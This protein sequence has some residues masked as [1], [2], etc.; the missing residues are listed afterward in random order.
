MADQDIHPWMRPVLKDCSPDAQVIFLFMA[1]KRKLMSNDDMDYFDMQYWDYQDKKRKQAEKERKAER[2]DNIKY[3]MEVVTF[4]IMI[5]TILYSYLETILGRVW[6]WLLSLW[7]EWWLWHIKDWCSC[8]VCFVLYLRCR[9]ARLLYQRAMRSFLDKC[10]FPYLIILY[11][12]P[13]N[14]R[15]FSEKH[16][17]SV[18][19]RRIWVE[20][21]GKIEE[22]ILRSTTKQPV[23]SVVFGRFFGRFRSFLEK[24]REN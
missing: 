9:F 19:N 22:F 21:S 20:F 11:K 24:N 4:I 1:K 7:T 23:F 2:R 17:I 10:F 8:H 15:I 12:T 5:L 14:I 13:A 16:G 18:E 3:W 6:R